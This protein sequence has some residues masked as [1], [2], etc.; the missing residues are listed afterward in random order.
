MALWRL[1]DKEVPRSIRRPW[2]V[3]KEDC[4]DKFDDAI[5]GGKVALADVPQDVKTNLVGV[6]QSGAW[7]VFQGLPVPRQLTFLEVSFMELSALITWKSQNPFG[8]MA[9][10]DIMSGDDRAEFVAADP[11]AVIETSIYS[12]L[13]RERGRLTQGYP[14]QAPPQVVKTEEVAISKPVVPANEP[15]H[16]KTSAIG[17]VKDEPQEQEDAV[18]VKDI[19]QPTTCDHDLK[20]AP[21]LVPRFRLRRKGKVSQT[22]LHADRVVAAVGTPQAAGPPRA[23]GTPKAAPKTSPKASPKAAAADNKI[24]NARGKLVN[25]GRSAGGKTRWE[26][27]DFPAK[28]WAGAMKRSYQEFKEANSDACSNKGDFFSTEVKNGAQKFLP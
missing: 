14:V 6:Q 17:A 8:K 5:K 23:A 18:P 9:Q 1:F 22:M 20:S 19:V 3:F 28:L 16:S 21:A 4:Q 24:K 25:R 11:H 7:N 12:F 15:P 13:L 10:W 27:N 2:D 26:N